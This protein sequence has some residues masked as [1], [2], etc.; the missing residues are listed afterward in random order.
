MNPLY[1]VSI[2]KNFKLSRISIFI[3]FS[4]VCIAVCTKEFLG[5]LDILNSSIDFTNTLEQGWKECSGKVSD[6]VNIFHHTYS[7]N[8]KFSV[9]LV[10]LDLDH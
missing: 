2:S 10:T 9:N 4:R 7:I 3:R 6:L 8:N 5:E 1:K